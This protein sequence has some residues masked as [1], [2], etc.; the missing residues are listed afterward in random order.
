M[1]SPAAATEAKVIM[2]PRTVPSRP[3]KGPPEMAMVS[4]TIHLFSFWLSRTWPASSAE[5]MAAIDCGRM[6]NR[7]P[8]ALPSARR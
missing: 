8:D 5:R 2:T 1:T 6:A 4:S 3:M 7:L